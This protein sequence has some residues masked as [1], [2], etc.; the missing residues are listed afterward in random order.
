MKRIPQLLFV[1]F[2]FVCLPRLQAQA[3]IEKLP[4]SDLV[5]TQRG[6]L[7]IILSAPHGGTQKVPD[8]PERKGEGLA[9]GSAGF[10]IAFDSNTDLLLKELSAAL[11]TRKQVS[12]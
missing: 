9:K 8:V 2:S 12:S 11:E 7:P 6:E 4:T 10:S 3:P 5:A 1:L